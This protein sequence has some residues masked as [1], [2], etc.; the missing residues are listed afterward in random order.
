MDKLLKEIKKDKLFFGAIFTLIITA[1]IARIIFVGVFP[2]GISH[3]ELDIVLSAKTLGLTGKDASGVSLLLSLFATQLESGTTGLI[4][5]LLMP[6]FYF[7]KLDLANVHLVYT[8]VVII[9][10]FFV[11]KTVYLFTR[12]LKISSITFA[13]LFASPWMFIYSN[14]AV[15]IPFALMFLSI[16]IAILFSQKG[17]RVFIALPFFLLSMF[18]YYGAMATTPL[19][20]LLVLLIHSRNKKQTRINLVMF[21]VL[22]VFLAGFIA[23]SKTIPNSVLS[24]RSGE[25]TILSLEKYSPLVD[26]AR[27][28]T[29]NSPLTGLLVNKPTLLIAD[30]TNKYLGAFSVNTLFI[31]GDTRAAYNFEGHGLLYYID[32]VFI[33]LGVVGIYKYGKRLG[34]LIG[35]I[36]V[37]GPIGSMLTLVD[38]SYIFRSYPLPI[39]FSILISFG[40]WFLYKKVPKKHKGVFVVGFVAIYLAFLVRFVYFYNFHYSIRQAENHYVSERILV[41]YAIRENEDV[42]IVV[43]SPVQI[44]NQYAFFSQDYSSLQTK[45]NEK[46]E[47]MYKNLLFTEKCPD[48]AGGIVVTKTYD[49]C[50]GKGTPIVIQEQKDAGYVYSIFGSTICNPEKLDNYRRTHEISDYYV[51]DM[52]NREFCNRWIAKP[53]PN[54]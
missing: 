3:D 1:V 44:L 20:A 33:L 42:I 6:I 14:M 45:P 12:N 26:Q 25:L 38:M 2:P 9:T 28:Q 36:I 27:K 46:G 43:P 29:I 41:D 22:I 11:S 4:P 18:S 35:A 37:F 13:V 40:I 49:G 23:I 32:Y 50:K 53:L 5:I 30:L 39:A 52:E 24:K 54:P 19:L 51:E 8:I 7:L 10:A 21:L 31:N 34:L 15:D 17:W 48:E 47:Y 16:G